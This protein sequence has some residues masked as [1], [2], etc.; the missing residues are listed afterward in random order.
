M[1]ASHK[2][3]AVMRLI[4]DCTRVAMFLLLILAASRLWAQAGPPFQT[5]D[6]TPVDYGHYE[7]YVFGTADGTPVEMDS[8]GPAFEFN[9][10]AVPRIQLHVILPFGSINPS[11]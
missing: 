4:G 5:D 3:E 9:W 1:S 8:T 2:L 6:P 10:G 7:F 11:N